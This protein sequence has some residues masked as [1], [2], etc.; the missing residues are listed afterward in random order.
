MPGPADGPAVRSAATSLGVR[1]VAGKGLERT[2]L[3]LRRR[4]LRRLLRRA[5]LRAAILAREFARH[6][7]GLRPHH[8]AEV[9]IYRDGCHRYQGHDHD[10][11]RQ[12]MAIQAYT[13]DFPLVSF[14]SR[15]IRSGQ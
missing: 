15:P 3:G 12:T 5:V 6:G 10:V 13:T 2:G 8:L 7:G 9:L 1:G 4:L 11:F 14:R